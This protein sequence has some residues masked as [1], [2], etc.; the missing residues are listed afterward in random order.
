VTA[1]TLGLVALGTLGL[2]ANGL[3]SK[4]SF[5]TNP[6]SVTGEEVLAR[7][8]PA[9][10]G[11]PVQVIGRAEA[12]D[13]LRSTLAGTPGVTAVTEPVVKTWKGR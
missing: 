3:Q 10:A 5:R 8:F 1:L 2:D 4:D 9:G 11:N 6:E 12:A 13:Q 7:H